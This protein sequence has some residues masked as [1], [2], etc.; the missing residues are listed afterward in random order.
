MAVRFRLRVPTFHFPKGGN[1]ERVDVI[2]VDRGANIQKTDV[3]RLE[4]AGFLVVPLDG[5][6]NQTTRRE[7]VAFGDK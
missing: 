1:M 2:F 3:V 7:L 6:P 4:K 5:N